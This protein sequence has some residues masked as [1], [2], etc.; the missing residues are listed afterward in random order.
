MRVNE[1]FYSLQGE[2]HY[3]GTPAVFVRLAGCNLKCPF[4]D[5]AHE[6]FTEMAD[7]QILDR[8]A[9][10]P[11]KRVILTGGE[12]ALQLTE[13]FLKLLRHNGYTI[14]LET[15]GTMPVPE[16]LIDW[17]VCSPKRLPVALGRID[18][19]KVVYD[20]YIQDDMKAV[21]ESIP[22]REYYIQPC[23]TKDELLNDR[24]IRDAVDFVKRN[25]KWRLSLQTHKLINI[26]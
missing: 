4:C 3:T 12:P 8:L 14:H 5:T 13:S 10:Y 25:P 26:P 18:E 20:W 17:I 23:D 9:E 7:A 21:F 6:T 1:I 24:I 2:G 15:N 19:L 16:E 22:A 11:A